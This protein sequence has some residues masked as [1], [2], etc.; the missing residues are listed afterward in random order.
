VT[1]HHLADGTMHSLGTPEDYELF[2]KE[3][4]APGPDAAR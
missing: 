4:A 3:F 2:L 1:T